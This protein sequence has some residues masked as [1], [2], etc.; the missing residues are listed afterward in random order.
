MTGK[1]RQV[2]GRTEIYRQNYEGKALQEHSDR[3]VHLSAAR[4][5]L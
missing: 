3:Y 4:P 5:A 1:I 2:T